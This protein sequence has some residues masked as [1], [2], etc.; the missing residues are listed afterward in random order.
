MA[1]LSVRA[2]VTFSAGLM[3][4]CLT[5]SA[6]LAELADP[7][8]PLIT[9]NGSA[10]VAQASQPQ[11]PTLNFVLI[12]N[13]RRVA[14]IDGERYQENDQLQGFTLVKIWQRRVTLAKDGKMIDIELPTLVFGSAAVS[15]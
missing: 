15:L 8:R 12:N 13:Q 5:A 9:I 10:S 2:P 1:G 7:T 4:G 11:M 6:A 14:I 3:L